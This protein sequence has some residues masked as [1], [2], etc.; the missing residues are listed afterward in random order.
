V[1]EKEE[2]KKVIKMKKIAKKTKDRK[3]NENE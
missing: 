2:Y 3:I 1:P